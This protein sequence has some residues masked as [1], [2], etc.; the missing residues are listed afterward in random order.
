[1]LHRLAL[2]AI[3]A[4]FSLVETLH[5]ALDAH[6]TPEDAR[7]TLALVELV[8]EAAI[9]RCARRAGVRP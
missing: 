4:G 1:M 3:H 8:L 7:H 2:R 5:T 6:G 9:V